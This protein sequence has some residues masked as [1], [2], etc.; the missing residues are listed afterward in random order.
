MAWQRSAQVVYEVVDGE[1]LLIDPSGVEL[2]TLNPVGALVW[3][4]LDG[5]RDAA[6]LADALVDSFEGV[7]RDELTRDIEMFLTE[8][9]AAGLI[10]ETAAGDTRR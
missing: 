9:H 3:Q 6:A 5:S 4:A 1:A 2:I 10:S 8:L 7:A